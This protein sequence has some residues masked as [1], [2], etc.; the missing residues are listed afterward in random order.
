MPSGISLGNFISSRRES[1]GYKKIQF[2]KML[3]VDDNTLR[4]WERG[5]FVPA[6]K[7]IYSLVNFL[8]M[9]K[10]EVDTYFKGKY[11]APTDRLHA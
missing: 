1:L 2:S 3:D 7:N 9:N 10:S 5:R 6:G 8:K 4:D 11:H